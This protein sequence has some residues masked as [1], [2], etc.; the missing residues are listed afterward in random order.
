MGIF[1]SKAISATTISKLME[2]RVKIS[3]EEIITKYPDGVTVNAF[4]WMKGDDG[5][6]PVCTFEENDGECFF[7]GTALTS[8]CKAWQEGF[9]TPE[10]CSVA[11][12]SEGGVKL[13]FSKGKTKNNRNFT[14]CEVVD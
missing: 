11:L 10:D 3:T 1:K 4:D 9:E 13:K 14:K 8:I 2:G 5:E 7:G 6:Y 12:A